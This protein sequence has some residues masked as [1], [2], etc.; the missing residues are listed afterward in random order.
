MDVRWMKGL[1]V[2]QSKDRRSIFSKWIRSRVVHFFLWPLFRWKWWVEIIHPYLLEFH[3]L[4]F[5]METGFASQNWAVG[6][7]GFHVFFFCTKLKRFPWFELSCVEFVP[8]SREVSGSSH[9]HNIEK[10]PSFSTDYGPPRFVQKMSTFLD[11]K[12][13]RIDSFWPRFVHRWLG[14]GFPVCLRVPLRGLDF[15]DQKW[16]FFSDAS[17]WQLAT[18]SY[19]TPWK[20]TWNPKIAGLEV[21][22]PFERLFFGVHVDFR[23]SRKH[24]TNLESSSVESHIWPH[25]PNAHKFVYLKWWCC[26]TSSG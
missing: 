9:P 20:V 13:S 15:G 25:I 7:G 3:A 16:C 19:L 14:L 10:L 5:W 22:F 26:K 2:H 11:S 8:N 12:I 21:D 1:A 18:K 4:F 23:G 6:T 24:L 17:N